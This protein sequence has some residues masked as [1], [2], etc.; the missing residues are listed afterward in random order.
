MIGT[1]VSHYRVLAELGVGGMG[2]VYRAQDLR[3]GRDVALKFLP[4]ALADDRDALE[5]FRRE[6]RLASTLNHPHICT[7]HDIDQHDGRPFIVME[8]LEGMP[9][10]RLVDRGPLPVAQ[11]LDMGIEIAAALEAAHARGIVHRD[12]KPA[13]VFVTRSGLVKVLDFGLAKHLDRPASALLNAQSAPTASV[14]ISAP[15]TGPGLQ[16]GT[17]AYMS[18]EQ[19]KGLPV[20]HRTD[21]FSLGL[22]L[23]EMVTGRRAFPED[24]PALLLS[25]ILNRAVAP[26]SELNPAVPQ[27]LEALIARAT[28]K[29][30]GRRYHR[31]LELGTELRRIRRV[32]AEA[33]A[34][35]MT[36]TGSGSPVRARPAG[37]WTRWRWALVSASIAAA[38]AAAVLLRQTGRSAPVTLTDRDSILL[39]QFENTTGEPVFDDSLRQALAVQ[40]GQSPFLNLLAESRVRETLALMN[41]P[42]DERLTHPVARE[43]CVRGG[44]KAMLEGSISRLGSAYVVSLVATRCD[45][46]EAIA[47]EQVQV[48]SQERVLQA[49][50]RMASTMRAELGESLASIQRFDVPIEQATTGSLDALKA[51]TLGLSRRAKGDE[52][53]SIPFFERAIELDPEF[54]SAYTTLST[55]YGSIGESARAEQYAH[56]AF[57]RR[58][59]VSERERLFITYQYHDRVTGDTVQAIQ[60]LQMWKQSFPRDATPA[61]NLALVYNRQGRFTQAVD[62]GQEALRRNPEHPFPYSNLAHAYRGLNR[63]ADAQKI[64]EAAVARKIETIPTRRLLYQL[65]VIRG[66][67]DGARQWLDPSRGRSRD[68]EL[69]FAEGQVAAFE[70]RLREARDLYRRA[71]D[72]AVLRNLPETAS[73]YAAQLAWTEAIYGHAAHALAVGREI[74]RRWPDSVPRFRAAAA[75]ALAG[76]L[77]A[78]RELL[79]EATRR[80]PSSTY[81]S[82]VFVPITGAAIAIRTGD[83]GTALEAL[84][85]AEPFELG[86]SAAL[87]PVYLR[88]EA[89]L[90]SAR[91]MEAAAEFGRILEHRGSDPFSPHYPLAMLGRAR[92]LAGTPAESRAVYEQLLTLWAR[93]DRDLPLLEVARRES[94]ALPKPAR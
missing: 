92:A 12:I 53:G 43:V 90:M 82:G 42:E 65:A 46:D 77:G 44:L 33:A 27:E 25:A 16:V 94:A 93:A 14:P 60:A 30:P 11:V 59:A 56:E 45:T 35:G 72:T 9:L 26:A 80:Y 58:D 48:D 7:I 3:L 89:L 49:V 24:N 87:A 51:Y 55:V 66:D 10:K 20:D 84:R 32:V 22:V 83:A 2:V 39:A 37:R 64:A 67:A 85:A 21:I 38:L 19:A 17:M 86:F 5:R 6:A 28:E 81:V 31:A 62:E 1:T 18:P 71:I 8:L 76:D 4:A 36:A 68:F 69:L 57:A 23:Y 52:L 63:Y 88:G 54:A 70:G 73:G 74:R 41:R 75:L 47:R 79:A 15:L 29:D 13:N 91:R 78:S 40:L 61:N 50:G 34:A